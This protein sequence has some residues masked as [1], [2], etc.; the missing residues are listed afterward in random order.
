MMISNIFW[1]MYVTTIIFTMI[2][3]NA[4]GFNKWN[5]GIR[6]GFKKKTL[7]FSDSVKWNT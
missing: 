6:S 7:N 3:N 5:F 4:F 2:D 1:P